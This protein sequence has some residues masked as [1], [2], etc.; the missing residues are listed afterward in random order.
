MAD[1]TEWREVTIR[2]SSSTR[3]QEI[4]DHWRVT[5]PPWMVESVVGRSWSRSGVSAPSAETDEDVSGHLR[6]G[7][8]REGRKTDLF[9]DIPS[10]RV[11]RGSGP[12]RVTFQIAPFE[13]AGYRSASER[14]EKAIAT[15][16]REMDVEIV[17][18]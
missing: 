7:V 1:I 9:I 8:R 11:V 16:P 17:F 18:D 15:L 4:D 5:L 6:F 2:G 3:I 10:S 13:M 12:N 14:A